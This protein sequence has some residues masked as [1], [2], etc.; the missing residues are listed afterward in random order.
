MGLSAI[1]FL[2]FSIN[3]LSIVGLIVALGI[4]VDDSIVVVENIERWMRNGY[5][6]R[7]AAVKATRQITLA[8]VGCTV[9]LILAFLP[10]NFLPEASGDFIRSLPMAVTMTILA[11]MIVSLTIVPFLSSRLLKESHNPE[12]NF[13]LRG[14]KKLISGSYSRLLHWGLLHPIPTLGVAV[15]IFA[16]SLFIPKSIWICTFS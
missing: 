1:D 7:E 2:G 5:P 10:L 8:V 15:L 11:S 16:S 12:G 6:K 4:L 14:L 3:Q 13:F 9:T